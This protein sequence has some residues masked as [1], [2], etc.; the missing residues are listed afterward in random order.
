MESQYSLKQLNPFVREVGLQGTDSWRLLQRRIYDHELMYCFSG[1]AYLNVN[2]RTHKL[3]RGDLAVIKPDTPHSFW[4]DEEHPSEIVWAHFDLEPMDDS[5]W[6]YTL[7]NTPERYA[8]LFSNR[9]Q[10][11]EHIRPQAV[12]GED[13]R[14]PDLLHLASADEA[15]RIL[16]SLH[17]AYARKD[18]MF[19]ITSKIHLLSLLSLVFMQSKG[20]YAVM[21][22]ENARVV[23]RVKQYIDGNFAR[24]LSMDAIASSV[25]LSPDYCGR[26]FRK[27]TGQTVIEYL[28]E[29]R[30]S[31]AKH[32]LLD[33]DLSI[34]EVAEMAGLKRASYFNMVAKK[35]TGMTPVQLRRYMLSIIENDN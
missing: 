14:L 23:D 31:R 35:H 32:L 5:D 10:Y 30:V 33:E 15:E 2:G 19:P 22:D 28:S 20:I 18:P 27:L 29:V 16:R 26:L 3:A 34:T 8:K 13:F 4:T 11:P 6:L 1:R 9:L 12:I 17:K 24:K 7:Y 25:H 21:D